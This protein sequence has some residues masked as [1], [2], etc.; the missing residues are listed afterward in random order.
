MLEE[1]ETKNTQDHKARELWR[2]N[3]NPNQ[4]PFLSEL[5]NEFLEN[6]QFSLQHS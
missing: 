5:M 1:T 2:K 6:T 4:D 3:L